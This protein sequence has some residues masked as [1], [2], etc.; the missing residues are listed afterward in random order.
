MLVVEKRSW[1]CSHFVLPS[2]VWSTWVCSDLD[3]RPMTSRNQINLSLRQSRN[4]VGR[5]SLQ[6]FLRFHIDKNVPD[7][8]L[9]WGQVKGLK[10]LTWTA[11]MFRWVWIHLNLM[12][13]S[14]QAEHKALV[15]WLLLLTS[16]VW[17]LKAVAD[18]WSLLQIA[19]YVSI[20]PYSSC[21]LFLFLTSPKLHNS[22]CT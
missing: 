10:G 3:L 13:I 17:G 4:K 6:A 12:K 9:D 16:V 2:Q 1:L 11:M 19:F 18:K 20:L 14:L 15:R 5:K 7:E 21:F 8:G 22:F